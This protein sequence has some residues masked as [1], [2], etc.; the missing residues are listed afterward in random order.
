MDCLL[1]FTGTPI[2]GMPATYH[3]MCDCHQAFVVEVINPKTVVIEIYRKRKTYTL[4]KNGFWIRKGSSLNSYGFVTFGYAE[5]Y[6]S[7]ER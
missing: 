5:D 4:R 3:I 6:Q 2:V 7:P 1:P